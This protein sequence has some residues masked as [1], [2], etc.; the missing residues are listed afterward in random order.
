M[1]L[2]ATVYVQMLK[3]AARRLLKRDSGD[4]FVTRNVGAAREFHAVLR[5]ETL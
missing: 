3:K 5:H 4:N 1:K 2:S